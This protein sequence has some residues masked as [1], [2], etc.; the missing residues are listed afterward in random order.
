MPTFACLRLLNPFRAAV[1]LVLAG[2]VAG[3]PP[4]Q[5]AATTAA[6]PPVGHYEGSLAPVG[7]PE[8]RAALDIR[9]PSPGHYEAELTVPTAPA[10]S[11]VA[12]TV[13][14]RHNRLRLTRPARPG[15]T[16]ALTLDG[17]F[18]RGTLALDSARAPAILVR[19]G[20]PAPR[21][22][23]TGKVPQA[24]GPVW[25]FAPADI[26]TA[27]PAL[28]LLPDAPAATAASMWADALA[29]EGIIVLVLPTTDSA[30]A[31][32]EAPR[33]QTALQLLRRTAGADTANLGVWAVGRRAG[34]VA[35]ALAATDGLR[36]AFVIAQNP[37]LDPP[38][39]TA[40]RE[41]RS[42]K[43]PLLGLCGGPNAAAQARALRNALGSGRRGS[44]VH[45]YGTAGANLLVPGG[46][47]P[48]FASGLP[49]EVVR[50]L[51]ER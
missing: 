46:W 35:Q 24:A 48:R 51:R 1:L 5:D 30:S 27:G 37:T 39:K 25:L 23:R 41:L 36:A 22:Y 7:Q 2:A 15:Q 10:L 16:L 42:R 33:L 29:R 14:F 21:T 18:W 19:R 4:A 31:A 32:D 6:T 20:A 50:W 3:C 11:F 44:A 28:V 43:L 34:A 13:F 38:G 12:D 47:S 40:F 49:A 8:V 9:H 17:D 26:S 45:V